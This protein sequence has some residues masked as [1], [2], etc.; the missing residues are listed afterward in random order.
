MRIFISFSSTDRALARTLDAALTKRLPGASRFLD[1]R[2]LPGGA[3][4]ISRLAEE[5]G[6]ADVVLLL[7]GRQVGSWQELEYYEALALSRKPERD[8]RPR[9]VPLIAADHAPGL[10]FLAMLHH[11]PLNDPE[12]PKF[13][14]ALQKALLG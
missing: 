1:E 14:L 3:Y 12:D 8:G 6:T 10:P 5:L 4:W 11:I 2:S 7:L 13:V 9:I